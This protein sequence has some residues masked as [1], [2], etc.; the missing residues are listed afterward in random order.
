VAEHPDL[1][2]VGALVVGEANHYVPP[3]S[4]PE[5]YIRLVIASRRVEAK[6]VG[7]QL[8]AFADA[9][10]RRLGIPNLRVDCFAG[11]SGRLIEFYESCGYSRTETFTVGKWP[12][13]LLEKRL[14][15]D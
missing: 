15:L 12:G 7:R 11:G 9:E 2:V 8:M 14:S 6:G 1:G 3:A 4:Q 13:Q 5:L 10:A